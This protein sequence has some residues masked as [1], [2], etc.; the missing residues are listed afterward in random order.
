MVWPYN[1]TGL[2]VKIKNIAR[3]NRVNTIIIILHNHIQYPKIVHI[4]G[5]SEIDN[6]DNTCRNKIYF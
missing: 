3:P 4:H 6:R 2:L 1:L 5:A